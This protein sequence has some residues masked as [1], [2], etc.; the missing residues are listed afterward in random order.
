MIFDTWVDVN[1]QTLS[2]VSQ[3]DWT[4]MMDTNVL[5]TWGIC[6]WNICGNA[7]VVRFWPQINFMWLIIFCSIIN[8]DTLVKSKIH[9]AILAM[10]GIWIH[11][12]PS[13]SWV[14]YKHKWSLAPVHIM[15]TFDPFSYQYNESDLVLMKSRKVRG[16]KMKI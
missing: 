1:G 3:G 13:K 11:Y 14:G 9:R 8:G 5:Y 12:A 6:W 10:F 4:R 2:G 7:V 16:E 15:D